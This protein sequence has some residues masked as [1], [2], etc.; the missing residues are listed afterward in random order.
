MSFRYRQNSIQ[1]FVQGN[2]FLWLNK[3][4]GSPEPSN[5]IRIP[6]IAENISPN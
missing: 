1:P 3:R 4:I 6:R 2:A 5:P